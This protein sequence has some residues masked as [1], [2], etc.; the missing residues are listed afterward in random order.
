MILLV[1]GIKYKLWT[2]ENE[3]KIEAMVKEHFN[4]IFGENSLYFDIKPAFR[5][6]ANIGS[7]P[8]GFVI[9]FVEKRWYI[10]EVE[11]AE[12]DIYNHI[13]PQLSKFNTALENP[14]TKKQIADA[15]YDEIKQDTKKK[16][17][18]IEKLQENEVYKSLTDILETKPFLTIIIDKRTREV[19]EAVK[20]LPRNNVQ[21][22]I[23]REFKTFVS[24]R[25]DLER[26]A[27]LFEPIFESSQEMGKAEMQKDKEKAPRDTWESLLASTE[28]KVREI[29]DTLSKRITTE[30]KDIATAVSGTDF[31]FYWGKRGGKTN[32]AAFILRKE[33]L[34]VRIRFDPNTFQDPKCMVS[35]KKYKYW[36][37]DGFGEERAFRI[38]D[39]TQIDDAMQ[40]IRQSYEYTI[41][42][43]PSH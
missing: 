37:F 25:P 31:I 10:I 6:K 3:E 24:E 19:E 38:T 2:P 34:L 12:H 32:F 18:A 13:V 41:T 11:R 30:L 36:F 42:Q 14:D 7:K 5:S 21:D 35:A 29:V 8:D 9:D 43:N 16:K 26:H 1:D 20:A 28:Q 23:V 17:F 40:L 39:K 27:H 33:S 22:I 4:E 15:I